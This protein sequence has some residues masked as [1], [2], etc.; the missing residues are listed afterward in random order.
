MTRSTSPMDYH[1]PGLKSFLKEWAEYNILFE[2]QEKIKN[3][4]SRLMNYVF[5]RWG[6]KGATHHEVKND[7]VKI[8]FIFSLPYSGCEKNYDS[9]RDGSRRCQCCGTVFVNF[10][11]DIQANPP[12]VKH[13]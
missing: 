6:A 3:R 12:K 9:L 4:L 1:W 11:V 5:V 10:V 2:P 13:G 8:V 7:D